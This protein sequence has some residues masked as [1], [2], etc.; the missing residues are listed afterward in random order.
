MKF[1]EDSRVK[2]PAI[3]HLT[4]LGYSY[5]SLK[6]LEWDETLAAIHACLNHADIPSAGADCDYC[7]YVKARAEIRK[8]PDMF[9]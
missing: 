4:R 6:E 9:S 5:L 7:A 8:T 2:I 3:L 1:N